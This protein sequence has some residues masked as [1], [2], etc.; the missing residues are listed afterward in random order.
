MPQ[1]RLPREELFGLHKPTAW[2]TLEPRFRKPPSLGRSAIRSAGTAKGY[3]LVLAEDPSS[4]VLRRATALAHS[5]LAGVPPR[6][7]AHAPF[8]PLLK[9]DAGATGGVE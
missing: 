2:R 4:D 5:G 1:W 3:P 8:R 9:L 7:S 6:P